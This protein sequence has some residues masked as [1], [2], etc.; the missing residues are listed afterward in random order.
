MKNKPTSLLKQFEDAYSNPN[1]Y[2]PETENYPTGYGISCHFLTQEH[3][4]A[5]QQGKVIGL[6]DGEYIHYIKVKPS[7]IS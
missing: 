6:D 3:L 5:L 7:K 4:K 2:D 1:I